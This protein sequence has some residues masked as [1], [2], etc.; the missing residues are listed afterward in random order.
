MLSAVKLSHIGRMPLDRP[1]NIL[2]GEPCM[3]ALDGERELRGK[4]GDVLTFTVTR[5]GPWRVKI[6]EA[7]EEAVAQDLFRLDALEYRRKKEVL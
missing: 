4:S 5:K 2:L 7:L 3:I 6:R 1:L